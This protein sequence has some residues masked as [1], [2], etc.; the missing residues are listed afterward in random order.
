MADGSPPDTA[1]T[2]LFGS[3]AA[4]PAQ[5]VDPDTDAVVRTAAAEAGPGG[6]GAV[7][8]VIRN[9][10]LKGQKSFSAVVSEPGAFEGY[11]NKAYTSLKA[12]SPQYNAILQEVSPVLSGEQSPVGEAD[13][14]FSPKGQAAKGREVPSWSVGQ[15]PV[16][17]VGGN[18]FY[19]GVYRP[20]VSSVD[21]RAEQEVFGASGHAPSNEPRVAQTPLP[22]ATIVQ[23]AH[24]EDMEGFRG[25]DGRGQPMFWPG[26]GPSMDPGLPKLSKGMAWPQGAELGT[27]GKVHVFVPGVYD[28]NQKE[29]FN[30][31]ALADELE[32]Q[33]LQMTPGGQMAL[34]QAANAPDPDHPGDS[35][36]LLHAGNGAF[37]GGM[38][39]VNGAIGY[40]LQGGQNLINRLTGHPITVSAADAASAERLGTRALL[41]EESQLHPVTAPL[42][43]TGAALATSIPLTEAGVGAIRGL[44]IAG[45]FLTGGAG[46]GRGLGNALVRGVSRGTAGAIE[47]GLNGA[48]TSGLSDRPIQDQ[49]A[50]GAAFGGMLRGGGSLLTD[51]GKAIGGN[52]I[53]S[54]N[55]GPETQN[56]LQT[57][58]GQGINLRAGQM[59]SSPF[60]RTLDSEL[61]KMPFTGYAESDA[62]QRSAFTRAVSRTFGE[63]ADGLT[64]EVMSR[65][66][67]RIGGRFNDVAS[68][69]SIPDAPGVTAKLNGV[70]EEARSVL[71]DSDVAPLQKQVANISSAFGSDGVMSGESY[72]AL[73]RKGSPLDRA[74]QSNNPNIRY[75]AGQLRNTLDD[76]L[77]ANAKPEDLAELRQA[78]LQ[79]KN[80]RTVE[81]LAE[82]AGPDGAISPALLKNAVRKSY[83]DYAY[84]GAGDIGNLAE[85]GQRFLKEPPN[86][87]TAQRL[88]VR[89]LLTGGGGLVGLGAG[90]SEILHNPLPAT[91]GAVGAAGALAA[92]PIAARLLNNPLTRSAFIDQAP[93]RW[94]V[95]TGY[96]LRPVQ[97]A[98][99][100]LGVQE[101][102]R[103]LAPTI[104]QPVA[105]AQ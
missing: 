59:S 68:R 51:T 52:L 18:Q 39:A 20:G 5:Q 93:A 78:R 10:A 49:I 46:V 21:P 102:N 4:A 91:I 47:G 36:V 9:R 22:P 25:Y 3:S 48:I 60:I 75:Y 23:P 83:G 96:G 74:L 50:T 31:Q 16:A 1:E 101:A 71:P 85:I 32:R 8:N 53:G 80:M 97:A 29:T 95:L 76:A 84:T 19:T 2:E 69:T 41:G 100:P 43:E 57:A 89:N 65:A 15:Q 77:E 105:Y 98:A 79:W 42:A 104:E 17:N 35:G 6:Y 72:Q 58:A 28:P 45:E 73:T 26:M 13:A 30:P 63:D 24:V 92:P 103:L 14:Y 27:D 94:Q 62:A 81:D 82:K 12:G 64:P 38:A 37:L 56:L 54:A 34:A 33:R 55:V 88:G 90:A 86:S 70:V 7:A 67:D 44:P 99:L 11:G 40:G 61:S 66:R 87:G